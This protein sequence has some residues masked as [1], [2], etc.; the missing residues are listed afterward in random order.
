[1]FSVAV[2]SPICI[3][4]IGACLRIVILSFYFNILF[5]MKYL[6]RIMEAGSQLGKPHG[7]ALLRFSSITLIKANDR[8][9]TCPATQHFHVLC[10]FVV[11]P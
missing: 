8:F 7:L 4:S 10:V 5:V 9:W 2:Y 6:R 1:M 11:V 3:C